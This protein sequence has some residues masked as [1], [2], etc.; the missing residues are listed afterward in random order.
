M[1]ELYRYLQPTTG[2]LFSI[3]TDGTTWYRRNLFSPWLEYCHKAE[4][5]SL[6]EWIQIKR[7]AYQALPAHLR[8]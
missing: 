5:I 1:T 4:D 3:R 2:W 6:E 8:R 7:K